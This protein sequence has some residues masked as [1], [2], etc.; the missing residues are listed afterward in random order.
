MSK[1]KSKSKEESEAKKEESK[2][3]P[4]YSVGFGSDTE[5]GTEQDT[6]KGTE[7]D[8]DSDSASSGSRSATTKRTFESGSEPNERDVESARGDGS[9]SEESANMSDISSIHLTEKSS[10]SSKKGGM[11][12]LFESSSSEEESDTEVVPEKEKDIS[13]LHHKKAANALSDTYFGPGYRRLNKKEQWGNNY[14]LETN[15]MVVYNFNKFRFEPVDKKTGKALPFKHDSPLTEKEESDILSCYRL[16]DYNAVGYL[17]RR[18][19]L[20]VCKLCGLGLSVSKVFPFLDLE[21]KG[22][23]TELAMISFCRRMNLRMKVSLVFLEFLLEEFEMFDVNREGT[24]SAPQA[25]SIIHIALKKMGTSIW[26]V[27][28]KEDRDKG[29]IRKAPKKLKPPPPPP[30]EEEVKKKADAKKRPW[31][32]MGIEKSEADLKAEEDLNKQESSSSEE[33]DF[34]LFDGE[35][36]LDEIKLQ[37]PMDMDSVDLTELYNLV[38][39]AWYVHVEDFA[40]PDRFDLNMRTKWYMDRNQSNQSKNLM[41]FVSFSHVSLFVEMSPFV[42]ENKGQ[43]QYFWRDQ[44]N[45]HI[46]NFLVR[47]ADH[48][49]H[50]NKDYKGKEHRKGGEEQVKWDPKADVLM[51][52]AVYNLDNDATQESAVLKEVEFR[53]MRD[54]IRAAYDNGT[55]DFL[56]KEYLQGLTDIISRDNVEAWM[57]HV[58]DNSMKLAYFNTLFD[59]LDYVDSSELTFSSFVVFTKLLGL[60][61]HKTA[62]DDMLKD[63]KAD[64]NCML[65]RT[66]LFSILTGKQTV[67]LPMVILWGTRNIFQQLDTGDPRVPAL[68][69]T[70][71]VQDLVLIV[72]HLYSDWKWPGKDMLAEVSKEFIVARIYQ[73]TLHELLWAIVDK[74]GTDASITDIQDLFRMIDT[75]SKGFI[76]RAQVKLLLKAI[77]LEEYKIDLSVR[78]IMK[79]NLTIDWVEF[80]RA[81]RLQEDQGEYW[82]WGLLN[83]KRA[84]QNVDADGT[85][86]IDTTEFVILLKKFG[87]PVS[88]EE[89][90]KYLAVIDT[91]DSGE[92]SFIEFLESLAE[93]KF[94]G[95]PLSEALSLENLA[96]LSA[97]LANQSIEELEKMM[98]VE[99]L[100]FLEKTAVKVAIAESASKEE[101]RIELGLS[102]QKT[103]TVQGSGAHKMDDYMRKQILFFGR[104]TIAM[105]FAVSIVTG[106]I[107]TLFETVSE[108]Y[109]TDN[110]FDLT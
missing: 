17:N 63:I 56:I 91:D 16:M 86:S 28:R 10:K 38:A 11:F 81:F 44:S 90:A 42:Y 108:V 59:L 83:L 12:G 49:A 48:H 40:N 78:E 109:Q 89:G 25:R 51:K 74:V 104:I 1:S 93:D 60:P 37:V 100:P 87:L 101:L 61:Y 82:P 32:Y 96:N 22:Q 58:I 27:H 33:E 8:T 95:T 77:Q 55:P 102:K 39:E 71:M 85:G 13:E 52:L 88:N 18:Q 9:D 98:N 20:V 64:G 35:I 68:E 31:Y 30:T 106:G 75:D 4:W 73:V 57:T 107:G 80:A 69:R 45:V 23:V 76:T 29:L 46:V 97:F 14:Q 62:L 105:A 72:Q 66:Q 36:P 92:V 24:I 53:D 99:N 94:M 47:P 65:S 15:P 67:T 6:E 7:N 110:Q 34:Y 103:D 26:D 43:I 54:R 84:F 41:D 79:G 21:N 2:Q 3:K 19:T 50:D 5:N 70:V